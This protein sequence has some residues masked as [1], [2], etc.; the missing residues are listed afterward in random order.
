MQPTE[1]ATRHRQVH[2]PVG[3]SQPDKSMQLLSLAD[4]GLTAHCSQPAQW[5]AELCSWRPGLTEGCD[6]GSN[7]RAP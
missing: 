7:I 4:L 5:A 3:G 2:M 1:H 6:M